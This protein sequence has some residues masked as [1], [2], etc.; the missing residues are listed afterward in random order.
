MREVLDTATSPDGKFRMTIYNDNS[1][2]RDRLCMAKIIN[3][4]LGSP[5]LD[6]NGATYYV[7]TVEADLDDEKRVGPAIIWHYQITS[8]KLSLETFAEG[9]IVGLAIKI[10]SEDAGEA[11]IELWSKERM[12]QLQGNNLIEENTTDFE[13][14][15]ETPSQDESTFQDERDF[16]DMVEFYD[17]KKLLLKTNLIAAIES[18][19]TY[20]QESSTTQDIELVRFIFHYSEK[21]RFGFLNDDNF[22]FEFLSENFINKEKYIEETCTKFIEELQEYFLIL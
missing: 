4:N 22:E 12:E 9:A 1:I 3:L 20:N 18:S 5:Q 13:V 6:E 11:T 8:N 15:E 10:K 19:P 17:Q 21:L 2:R 14:N 16:D 7:A